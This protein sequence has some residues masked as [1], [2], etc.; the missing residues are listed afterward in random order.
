M[1]LPDD[2]TSFEIFGAINGM[3]TEELPVIRT[4]T[5]DAM[6]EEIQVQPEMDSETE[7]TRR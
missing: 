3:S 4:M 1:A 6:E 7:T 2:A 5:S